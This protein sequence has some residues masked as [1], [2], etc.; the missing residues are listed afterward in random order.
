LVA[1]NLPWAAQESFWPRLTLCWHRLI[2]YW[3][4]IGVRLHLDASVVLWLMHKC[5]GNL[6]IHIV[7]STT[8]LHKKNCSLAKH[9]ARDHKGMHPSRGCT[10]RPCQLIPYNCYIKQLEH[11][12]QKGEKKC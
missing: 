11:S 4:D 8:S 3:C 5:H 10:F 7:S 1:H 6:G 9:H 12:T 2:L